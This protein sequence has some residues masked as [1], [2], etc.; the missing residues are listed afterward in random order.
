[1][2]RITLQVGKYDGPQKKVV[3]MGELL[4]TQQEFDAPNDQSRGIEYALYRVPK[5]YRVYEK[6]WTDG[7]GEK[8]QNYAKLSK[9]LSEAE[10]LKKF[11]TLADYAGIPDIPD[12]DPDLEPSENGKTLLLAVN[13]SSARLIP[14]T[15]A[16]VE[17]LIELAHFLLDQHD[18]PEEIRG[19]FE[20]A[21]ARF[22]P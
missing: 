22:E 3:F 1:M 19:E 2:Q 4:E 12:L 14:Y 8:R 6:R 13:H 7:Q 5:G 15:L 10:L 17:E 21:L 20:N 9:V 11:D 16:N 18:V